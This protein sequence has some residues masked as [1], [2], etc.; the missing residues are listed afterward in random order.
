MIALREI[1]QSNF[2][3]C[4]N[5]ERKSQ[6][7]VGDAPYVLAEVYIYRQ[8]STAYG[9]YNDDTMVGLVALRDR[10]TTQNYSFTDLFIADN[11]QNKGYAKGAVKKIIEK[12]KAEGKADTIDLFVHET[13]DIALKI[14]KDYGFKEIERAAWD[15]SF[16]K[17]SINI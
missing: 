15:S 17:C 10:P 11:Y 14:Y 6:R 12:F 1:D 7:Y 13:N 2:N 9:I 3:E 4:M 5:L 16:I 8:H